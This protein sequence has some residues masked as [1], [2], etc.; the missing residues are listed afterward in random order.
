M[1][2]NR[3]SIIRL[4]NL[5]LQQATPTHLYAAF[6]RNPRLRHISLT[7]GSG[8]THGSIPE[9]T[10]SDLLYLSLTFAAFGGCAALIRILDRL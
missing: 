9:H 10:M 3:R 1:Q 5:G 4:K 6:T 2:P 7:R 8:K